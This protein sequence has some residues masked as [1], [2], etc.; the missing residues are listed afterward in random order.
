[1]E[2]T[3]NTLEAE[4]NGIYQ[5]QKAHQH[6]V[7]QSNAIERIQKLIKL[8]NSILLH[9]EEVMDALQAD[10]GKPAFESL[11]T[12]VLVLVNEI[13]FACQNLATWMKPIET[14]SALNPIAKGKIIYEP[15]GV[16]LIIGPWNF[17]FILL[18]SPLIPTIAAGNTAVLKPSELTPCVS[19]AIRTIIEDCFNQNEVAV[20]EGGIEATTEILK[21]PFDHIFFTGSPKVG[22]IVM[23]AAAKNLA[24][25]TLELGGKSPVIIDSTADLDKAVHR[26]IRGKTLNAGQ[27]CM[28]P[29]YLLI[30]E[31]LKDLFIQKAK[32]LIE[33]TLF[34]NGT[35]EEQDFAQII[36]QQNFN[37]LQSLFD[38]AV[39]KGANVALGGI[40]DQAGRR[41]QPTI[42]TNVPL[43]STLMKEEIFGPILPVFTYK[44][45]E[46]VV[47]FVRQ[48]DKPLSYYIFS[49]DQ[50]MIDY[51][52]DNS[53]SGGVA[54]ND[55][56]LQAFDENLPFGGVNGSG[57]GNYHGIYGFREL[58]HAKGVFIQ[59]S[60]TPVD[61]FGQQPYSGKVKALLEKLS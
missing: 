22:K 20:I 10:F 56:M 34:K 44:S 31:P 48:F 61:E 43:D 58:S 42:L 16:V 39:A 8:K 19:N 35:F 21:V 4:I 28:G 25:V 59:S 60:E 52:I 49:A 27:I 23:A 38:D 32:E 51:L 54:V 29:D 57:M 30:A 3:E 45:K 53:S 50:H 26:V 12:E 6:L 55:I 1:M 14:A 40:F 37:R 18:L 7:K 15:K 13:D 9:K 24:S 11:T 2:T 41:I 33:K 17:P 5:T 47:D 46:E 36:N